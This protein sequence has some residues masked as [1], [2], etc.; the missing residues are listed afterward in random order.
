V[1]AKGIA[2]LDRWREIVGP[3]EVLGLPRTRMKLSNLE[4][5]RGERLAALRYLEEA[6]RTAPDH[7]RI[8]YLTGLLAHDA[9]DLDAARASFLRARERGFPVPVGQE[10]GATLNALANRALKAGLPGRAIRRLRESLREWPAAEGNETAGPALARLE[11]EV[12]GL[13]PGLEPAGDDLDAWFRRGR[14]L[15]RIGEA[16]RAIEILGGLER[17]LTRD[18]RVPAALARYGYEEFG[19]LPA[20]AAAYRRALALD[21]RHVEA[22]RGLVR[23]GGL[24]TSVR[25]PSARLALLEG[26]GE[27]PAILVARARALLQL[28]RRAEAIALLERAARGEGP[29]VMDALELLLREERRHG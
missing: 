25:R 24:E 10:L 11:A 15:G 16:M 13:H 1:A 26:L 8:H 20:A 17:A 29:D 3:R 2:A 27:E 9:G 23:C 21:P 22:R 19:D 5:L 28:D 12:R 6:A 18:P 14:L 4:R 7:P